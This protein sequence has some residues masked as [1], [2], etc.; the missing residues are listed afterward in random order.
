MADVEQDVTG[1]VVL[2]TSCCTVQTSCVLPDLIR[3]TEWYEHVVSSA[4]CGSS[5]EGLA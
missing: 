3:R 4:Y 1:D 2:S 5:L